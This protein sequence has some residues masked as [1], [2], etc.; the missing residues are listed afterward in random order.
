MT[1]HPL[2]LLLMPWG[3][4]GSNM[5]NA[6]LAGAG[7]KVFNEPLTGIASRSRGQPREAVAAAQMAWLADSLAPEALE[8]PALLNHA[9]LSSADPAAL[10][11]WIAA[12]GVRVV[13]LDRGD[14]AA[15]ALSSA[16]SEAWIAEGAA[17]G[18]AR[19]WSIARGVRFTPRIAPDKLLANLEHVREGRRIMA[20][21]VAG[22][23]VLHLF[24]E[25]LV[26]DMDGAMAALMRHLGLAWRPF[27]IRTSR[28]GADSLAQMVANPDELAAVL[29][30]DG[31]PTALLP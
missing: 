6:A 21:L 13:T 23:P 26:A 2:G 8:Q 25:D 30:A 28:F 22:R 29:R 18:E 1:G 3:R 4:V 15:V 16:R 9:A 7:V 20:E 10:R 14:D 31:G 19:N 11:D 24:Y 27:D 17:L 5:V 12:R